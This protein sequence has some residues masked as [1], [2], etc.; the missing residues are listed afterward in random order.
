MRTCCFTGHRNLPK[1]QTAEIKSALTNEVIKLIDQGV[2]YYGTGGAIG[3][4]TLAAQTIIELR[5]DYPQIKLI[6]I[7]P[8]RNQSD[9]WSHEDK[10][11]YEDIKSKADKVVY[12][13]EKYENDCMLKR[14]RHMVD[15]SKF[16]IA[17]WDG[18]KRGGT[19][20]TINYATKLKREIILLNLYGD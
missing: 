11:I 12:L 19:Y 17:A 20:Y 7:I 4:D 1:N 6:L 3:F 5:E 15:H 10:R 18:R 13:S 16:V 9:K 2:T 8:C 14:N